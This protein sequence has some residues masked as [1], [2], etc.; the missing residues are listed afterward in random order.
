MRSYL[1]ANTRNRR[2]RLCPN[3]YTDGVRFHGCITDVDRLF[4]Y[5][6]VRS[7]H[8][9]LESGLRWNQR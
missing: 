5:D 1:P 4:G 9:S 8:R 3:M 2:R 7:V 6:P